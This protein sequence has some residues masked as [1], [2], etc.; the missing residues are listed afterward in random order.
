M[1][2]Y[3]SIG[4]FRQLFTCYRCTVSVYINCVWQNLII[5]TAVHNFMQN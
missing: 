5:H 2:T 3:K 1:Y 4:M